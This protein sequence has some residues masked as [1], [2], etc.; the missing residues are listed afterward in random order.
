MN[1][2]RRIPCALLFASLL[3]AG[4]IYGQGAPGGAADQGSGLNRFNGELVQPLNASPVRQASQEHVFQVTAG[5]LIEARLDA[6]DFDT[7][8]QLIPPMGD[9]LYNDDFENIH[10]SRIATIAT[11]GGEWRAVVTALDQ[12][13]GA[14]GLVITLDT[15]ERTRSIS[16]ELTAATPI[17]AKGQRYERQTYT[18]EGAPQLII[19]VTSRNFEPELILHS[20]SGEITSQIADSPSSNVVIATVPSAEAGIWEIIATHSAY[21]EGTTGDY[22]IQIVETTPVVSPVGE[23]I[24]GEL[25][26]GG[27]RQIHGELYQEHTIAGSAESGMSVVLESDDFDPFLAVRSPSGEWYRDDDSGGDANAMLS[28]PAEAGDWLVITTS[29][30]ADEVGRYEL[31]V[32]R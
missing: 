32:Y 20:P 19:Q 16:G 25:V 14:Y 1:V 29:Y 22:T 3:Y 17:S 7:V 26:A 10:T 11:V 2:M 30:A 21:A 13:S 15:P 8:L 31:K 5:Q 9:T 12:G 18:V 28:L 23:L 4:S 6:D 24:E 27:P